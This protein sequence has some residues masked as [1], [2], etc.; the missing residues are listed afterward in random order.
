[1]KRR[2]FQNSIKKPGFQEPPPKHVQKEIERLSN[3]VEGEGKESSTSPNSFYEHHKS[4]EPK[5]TSSTSPNSSNQNPLETNNGEKKKEDVEDKG[6]NFSVEG[7]GENFVEEDKEGNK[8]EN[9]LLEAWEQEEENFMV[10]ESCFS[11]L[12]GFQPLLDQNDVANLPLTIPASIWK[13]LIFTKLDLRDILTFETPPSL[14][15][16]FTKKNFH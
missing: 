10:E 6:E 2:E 16:K 15:L 14:S 1:M 3:P 12:E 5:F 8:E 4:L 7:E 11:K 13:N 9:P